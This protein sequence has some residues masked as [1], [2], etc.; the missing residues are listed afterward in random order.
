[1]LD[2]NFKLEWNYK[3][4]RG[5]ETV[6]HTAIGNFVTAIRDWAPG[7]RAMVAEVL[8]PAVEEQFQ[9]AG[10]GTWAQLAPSTIKRKGHD[11]ILFDTGGMFR[12]FQTGGA[13]HIEEI[14]RDRLLWGSGLS[15]SLFHQTGTG[16]GFQQIIK[17]AGRGMPMRKIIALDE[18]KKR[19]MR[20]IL[21]RRLATIARRE[22]FAVGG[23]D[24]DA[25]SARRLG[26]AL[27]GV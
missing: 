24:Q 11:T 12:S 18:T 7:F 22:G 2:V 1:V 17:G 8:E 26:A 10:H 14:T 25:L 19:A 3:G 13:N 4:Q 16:A 27:L 21:V 23:G 6:F 5:K 9:T 20:S 15:R